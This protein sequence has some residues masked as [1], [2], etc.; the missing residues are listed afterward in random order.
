MQLQIRENEESGTMR[1]GTHFLG[2]RMHDILTL[3]QRTVR[4]IMKSA[5]NCNSH[6]PIANRNKKGS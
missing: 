4:Y 1:I 5:R 3:M 6:V 2:A